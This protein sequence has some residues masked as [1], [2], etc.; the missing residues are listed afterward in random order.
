MSRPDLKVAGALGAA[1][2]ACLLRAA[3]GAAEA[4]PEL[5][6]AL[7]S[8]GHAV[9]PG[10]GDPPGFALGDCGTQ[11]NLSEE[12][13][14]QAERIGA[15]FRANGIPSAGCSPASRAA[16]WRRRGSSGSGR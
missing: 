10:T 14:A 15:R 5:W 3:P 6:A 7:R 8:G 9:A 1:A 16:V 13:R 11:R 4:E 12:G 2:L